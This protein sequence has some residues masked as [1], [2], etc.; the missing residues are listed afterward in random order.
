MI[1]QDVLCQQLASILDGKASFEN[2]ICSVTKPRNIQVT[3][4]GRPSKSSINLS[5]AFES[6]DQNGTALC[7]SEL[8]VLQ[9]EINPV[10]SILT[11]HN[12]PISALH[13][14]WIYTNPTIL[15]LHS[16]SID[17]PIQFASKMREISRMLM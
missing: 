14:H 15:Y 8:A 4:L 10:C 11:K 13:N 16:E 6:F 7:L 5:Y 9:N 1:Q 17:Y 12:I 2:G 3:I